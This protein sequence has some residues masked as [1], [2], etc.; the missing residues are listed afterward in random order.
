M[1]RRIF[2]ILMTENV[3]LAQHQTFG[4]GNPN[5]WCSVAHLPLSP[6]PPAATIASALIF[7][8]FVYLFLYYFDFLLTYSVVVV[9]LC[10]KWFIV[11]V[12]QTSLLNVLLLWASPL[13]FLTTLANF[14]YLFFYLVPKNSQAIIT[15]LQEFRSLWIANCKDQVGMAWH[16]K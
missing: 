5:S 13:S 9:L 16:E 1:T 4:A 14:M 3:A 6:P 10:L 2:F 8:S 12:K 11:L 15:Q 7:G